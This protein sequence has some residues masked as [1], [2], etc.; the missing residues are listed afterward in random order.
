MEAIILEGGVHLDAI[1]QA[2]AGAGLVWSSITDFSQF[3]FHTPSSCMHPKFERVYFCAL[4][5]LSLHGQPN[6]LFS[7]SFLGEENMC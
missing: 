3:P 7:P 1:E 6:P 5:N 4:S 2:K